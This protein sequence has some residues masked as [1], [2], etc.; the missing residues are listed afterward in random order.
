[1]ETLIGLLGTLVMLF[2]IV[3]MV[4]PSLVKLQS[5]GKVFLWSVG[6]FIVLAIISSAVSPAPKE[7]ATPPV[8]SQGQQAQQKAEPEKPKTISE[9]DIASASISKDSIGTPILHVTLKNKTAKT[10]DAIELQAFFFNNFD[11]PVGKFGVKNSEP[12]GA[13]LQEKIGPNATYSADWNLAVYENATKVKNA[14]VLRV[15]FTDG[16]TVSIE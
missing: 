11:E 5:R 3:G 12:F 15:H 8:S 7:A 13:G 6:S 1:M 16:Q 4:K 2:L 14:Q 10:I 9:V